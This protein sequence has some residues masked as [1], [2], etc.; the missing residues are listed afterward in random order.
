VL[1]NRVSTLPISYLKSQTYLRVLF[2]CNTS[3]INHTIL[4]S[5]LKS[6]LSITGTALSWLQSYLTDRQQ[7]IHINNCTSSTTLL[8][9]GIPQ[10]SVLGALLFILYL[11]P[12]G[13]VIRHHG[14]NFHC[15][16]NDVQFYISTKSIT[17]TTHS[18][19]SN[20]LTDINS[21][22]DT[23]FLNLTFTFM[24]PEQWD[25]NLYLSQSL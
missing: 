12:L 16:A 22:M 14:L 4:L 7:F 13:N 21:W 11:L 1:E 23:N 17:S 6:S 24:Q 3:F 2:I 25:L 19:L 9:Q 18:T 10:G 15:Y 5:C 8:S 20:C